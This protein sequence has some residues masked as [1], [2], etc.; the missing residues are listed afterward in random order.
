MF[1]RQ[2]VTSVAQLLNSL[3]NSFKLTLIYKHTGV[4][5]DDIPRHV[6]GLVE[7]LRRDT[8][9]G[10][11]DLVKELAANQASIRS[12][13]TT[14]Y[15]YDERFDDIEKWLLFDGWRIEDRRLIRLS[16]VVGDTADIQDDLL[17]LI[18]TLNLDTDG[19]VRR[20]ISEAADDFVA[21]PSDFNGS[22]TKIRIVLETLVKRIALNMGAQLPS[23][24][25]RAAWGPA[26]LGLR[27]NGLIDEPTER[28]IAGVYTLISP[29]AHMP[30]GMGDEEWARLTRTFALG[31]CY[32]VVKLYEGNT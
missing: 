29:A 21:A 12:E 32:Y 2:T 22:N 7:M 19:A 15:V 13:A 27:T 9:S 10:L 17:D 6:F 23:A 3:N 14:K 28:T 24:A 11:H 8:D 5:A 4:E 25:G 1:S 20:L 30:V 16:P 31:I 18:D 26:L